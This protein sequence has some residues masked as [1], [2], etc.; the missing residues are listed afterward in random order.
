MESIKRKVEEE[1]LQEPEHSVFHRLREF[2]AV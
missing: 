2:D 1:Q